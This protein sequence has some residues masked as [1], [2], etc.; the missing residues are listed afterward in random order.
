MVLKLL[1]SSQEKILTVSN[2]SFK[3]QGEDALY[4]GQT[5]EEES[6]FI[7]CLG[8]ALELSHYTC[9]IE[10]VKDMTKGIREAKTFKGLLGEYTNFP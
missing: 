6:T 9:P 4:L 3:N 7:L 5:Q 8:V 1:F 10:K 2:D